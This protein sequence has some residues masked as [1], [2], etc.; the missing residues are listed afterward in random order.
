[1]AVHL[2]GIRMLPG[3]VQGGNVEIEHYPQHAT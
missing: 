3:A 2:W 1:M